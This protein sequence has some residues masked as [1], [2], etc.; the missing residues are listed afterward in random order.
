MERSPGKSSLSS[1]RSVN[2][3]SWNVLPKL[4]KGCSCGFSNP[5]S[6]PTVSFSTTH[7]I[8]PLKRTCRSWSKNNPSNGPS[9]TSSTVFDNNGGRPL[10]FMNLIDQI[11]NI[12]WLG[13]LCVSRWLVETGSGLSSVEHLLSSLAVLPTGPNLGAADDPRGFTVAVWRSAQLYTLFP[14]FQSIMSF[15]GQKRKCYCKHSN[16]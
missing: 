14:S 5:I 4:A 16:Q 6:R 13:S 15:Q 7:Q 11:N 10:F 9:G 2:Q 3:W 8:R 1:E 12:C